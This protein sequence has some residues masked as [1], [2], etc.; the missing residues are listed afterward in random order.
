MRIAILSERSEPKDFSCEPSNSFLVTHHYLGLLVF[1]QS[2][3]L[4]RGE[5]FSLFQIPFSSFNLWVLG[6][7]F[8][9]L[10]V[11]AAF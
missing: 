7:S 5:P 6:D 2:R 9:N 11:G 3:A 1:S 10:L 8:P 4:L